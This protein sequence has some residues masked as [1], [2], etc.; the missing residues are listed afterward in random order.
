[1][2]FGYCRFGC[3]EKTNIDYMVMVGNVG[4]QVCGMWRHYAE[5]HNVLPK[6]EIRDFIFG[7]LADVS[8]L[9]KMLP[10]NYPAVYYVGKKDS[11]YDH[12]IGSSADMEFIE[13]FQ[14]IVD[15][16]QSTISMG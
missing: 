8:N 14:R 13:K 3:G 4:L 15:K 6:K 2:G 7:K 5:K 1:M 9:P 11:E 16:G 10:L 12:E